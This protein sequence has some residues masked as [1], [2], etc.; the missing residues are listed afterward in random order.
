MKPVHG[1]KPV[2]PAS[3]MEKLYKCGQSCEYNVNEYGYSCGT[4]EAN[5][6][7]DLSELSS[8]TDLLQGIKEAKGCTVI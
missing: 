1:V 7:L 4:I 8:E 5:S 6:H 2:K 3:A